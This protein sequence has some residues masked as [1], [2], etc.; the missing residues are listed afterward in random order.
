MQALQMRL[1]CTGPGPAP[2]SP[3]LFLRLFHF[4]FSL[5]FFSPNSV[6]LPSLK[7]GRST[8]YKFIFL[9]FLFFA[10][11]LFFHHAPGVTYL[12]PYSPLSP[13]PLLSISSLN[14]AF[15]P[16]PFSL[17]ITLDRRDGRVAV[18]ATWEQAFSSAQHLWC[19]LHDWAQYRG[20]SGTGRKGGRHDQ[21][22]ALPRTTGT[23]SDPIP[24]SPIAFT[25]TITGGNPR[26]AIY[27]AR[28]LVPG[29]GLSRSIYLH[30]WPRHAYKLSRR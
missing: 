9:L 1:I 30:Q 20:C 21:F 24:F 6:K 25:F 19:L 16:T 8:V 22:V 3:H 2:F 28:L 26:H 15:P 18:T 10:L 29:A 7:P 11:C 13:L 12:H 14:T 4:A 27:D 23:P 5:F 17:S